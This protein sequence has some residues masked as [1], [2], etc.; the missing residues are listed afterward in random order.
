[1]FRLET[2]NI[3]LIIDEH[4]NKIINQ[5]D[6]YIEKLILDTNPDEAYLKELNSIRA[7]QILQIEAVKQFNLQSRDFTEEAFLAKWDHL[8]Q[9]E[10]MD[11]DAKMDF[12]KSDLIKHDC[13]LIEDLQVKSK[14][15]LWILRWFNTSANL[16]LLRYLLETS[17]V[18]HI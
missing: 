10:S 1:M 12:I 11:Y 2:F 7:K 17:N 14:M 15:A 16:K 3:N 5:L 8:I 4:F 6:I 18:I 9:N 13:V